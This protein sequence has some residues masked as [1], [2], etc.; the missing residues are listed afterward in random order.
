MEIHDNPATFDTYYNMV[1]SDYIADRKS[2][3]DWADNIR[4]A[5]EKLKNNARI[6]WYLRFVRFALATRADNE[7]SDEVA[8]DDMQYVR[9]LKEIRKYNKKARK[10]GATLIRIDESAALPA[11]IS[12][13]G[14]VRVPLDQAAGSPRV[15]LEATLRH[16]ANYNLP[17]INNQ[18]FGWLLPYE[19]FNLF[20]QYIEDA[21]ELSVEEA[22]VAHFVETEQEDV[23]PYYVHKAG[24]G[25]VLK[26]EFDNKSRFI[27]F[28]VQDPEDE[29]HDIDIKIEFEED[30]YEPGIYMWID[31][32]TENDD[33]E[34]A[35]MDHCGAAG[36][37]D[38]TL[39]SLRKLLEYEGHRFW[40]PVL[41][42]E[43]DEDGNLRQMKGYHNSKPISK[44]HPYIV[45]LLKHDDISGI[46]GGGYE[47]HKNFSL[48]DLTEKQREEVSE[49]ID[50]KAIG[51]TERMRNGEDV[52]E[53][54]T[55]YYEG[56]E[57]ET[58]NGSELDFGEMSVAEFLIEHGDS[59]IQNYLEVLRE[60]HVV[61]DDYINITDEEIE[62]ALELLNPRLVDA[63]FNL[64]GVQRHDEMY[65]VHPELE[66]AVYN[67]Y[68]NSFYIS[69]D[70]QLKAKKALYKTITCIDFDSKYKEPGYSCEEGRSVVL[71]FNREYRLEERLSIYLDEDA[72]KESP[73]DF[74]KAEVQL[75]CYIESVWETLQM[76]VEDRDI[77]FG[78]GDVY[79]S[80]D[81]D[82]DAS[83]GDLDPADLFTVDIDR[84]DLN[85]RDVI[86]DFTE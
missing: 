24:H 26:A 70:T 4:W 45:E 80:L 73:T 81:F 36:E 49:Y 25:Q 27:P 34:S 79:V 29:D 10:H 2:A 3:V 51:L 6:V 84:F 40:R 53:E 23:A 67:A 46:I 50:E 82:L 48:T 37:D 85:I 77:D 66:K 22:A 28:E 42:F 76:L 11:T 83:D 15:V 14:V 58:N 16:Y 74:V 57:I 38:A 31:L 12:A 61:P 54:F 13:F 60:E 64:V 47:A 33:T 30:E 5:I 71:D 8:S 65:R 63:L 56:E 72:I 17:A 39:L 18:P 86:D 41:T 9:T 1:P 44:Y 78:D 59:D 75:S 32:N 62:D 55:F 35:A 43:L 68:V 20:D 7:H 21:R 52:W 69:E 19:L